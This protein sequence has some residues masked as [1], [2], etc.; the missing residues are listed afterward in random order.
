MAIHYKGNGTLSNNPGALAL[1]EIDTDAIN[2]GEGYLATQELAD[3]VD[4]A[5]T[6]GMPLLLT[7]EPGCGKTRLAASVA[8]ELSLGE[9]LQFTVKSDTE[10]RDLFYSFDTLGRYRSKE[11]ANPVNF[12]RYNAFGLA[13]LRAKGKR[14]VERKDLPDDVYDLLPDEGCRSLVL[15]DEIDKAG[16]DVPNDLL[17]ELDGMRFVIPELQRATVALNSEEKRKRR[18]I[19]II[20]SN[21]ERS[22]P[23]PFLRRCV[24]YHIPFPPFA[25]EPA[26]ALLRTDPDRVSATAAPLVTVEDIVARRVGRRFD[27][28]GSVLTDALKLFRHLRNPGSPIARPPSMAE[29]LNWLCMLSELTALTT[30]PGGSPQLSLLDRP[31]VIA[32]ATCTLFKSD[33]DQREGRRLVEEWLALAA[34][35]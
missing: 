21:A 20:T 29:L 3:A 34:G 27:K 18:P 19:V 8:W 15:I 23:P 35:K 11:S 16:R 13:I 24:Y 10:G 25:Y 7:G 2:D 28:A 17:D 5:L 26:K 31:Q 12:I 9:P 32:A 22:L 1:P 33:T 30:V 6:L 14:G 4:V